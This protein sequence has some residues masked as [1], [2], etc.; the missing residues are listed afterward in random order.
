[1][2]ILLIAA[3]A[4]LTALLIFLAL[5]Y[6]LQARRARAAAI[7]GR[8]HSIEMPIEG[9]E[10]EPIL[11]D[12]RLSAIPGLNRILVRTGIARK[13]ERLL[14]MANIHMRVG[15]FLLMVVFLFILTGLIVHL[16]TGNPI[17]TTAGM[18]LAA[19]GP[20]FYAGRKKERRMRAF[21][22][23]FVEALDLINNSL[24]AGHSFPMALQNVA[25]EFPAPVGTEFGQMMQEMKLGVDPITSLESLAGRIDTPD[26]NFFVISV[27]IQ[28]EIGGN[29]SEIL[30]TLTHTVRERFKLSGKL[31]ALTAQHR[32]SGIVLMAFPFALGLLFYFFNPESILAFIAHPIGKTL[33]G[34]AVGMQVLG[35][36]LIRHITMVRV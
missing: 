15:A 25:G 16:S 23:Q 9:G 33:L 7:R 34:I 29:L 31:R 12:E 2:N 21:A 10:E 36:F 14:Y 30:D 8:L 5:L 6:G 18:L 28:N 13:V 35:F 24:R 4:S 22:E 11:R 32:F 1:M 27:K 17:Y 26:L 19:F 20:L 3:G